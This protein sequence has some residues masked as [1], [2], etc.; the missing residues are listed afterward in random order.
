MRVWVCGVRGS[1]PAPGPEFVR[2]GGNTSCVALGHGDDPP[3]LILDAGT[4]IRRLGGLLAGAPFDGALLLGHLHWDHTQGLPFSPS[5]DSPGSTVALH[6]PAQGDPVE[7][8]S[9]AMS[10]PHFPILP[11]DL[12][13]NWT[14]T[15][16]EAGTHTI[17]GFDVLALDIPHKGGR[18]FGYRITSP[19]SGA[20]MAYLS[21][22][23]PISVA[24][25]PDGLGEYHPAVLE[26]CTGVDVILHDAQYTAA[27]LPGRKDFGHSAIEYA[28]G[29]SERCG[30]AVLLYHHDPNRTDDALDALVA[31]YA[32]H[33]PPIAAAFEG[34]VL[35]LP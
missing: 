19:G 14:F 35:T 24:P 30:S 15:S 9:R 1:T 6:L 25:G 31:P 26:L 2:Y 22:H 17:A 10:P 28:V 4:G 20:S 11:T 18:T 16:L 23:W 34:Q 21:D 5:L 27:E 29:L 13:G 7:V 3:S 12:R 8:L 32:G 33:V